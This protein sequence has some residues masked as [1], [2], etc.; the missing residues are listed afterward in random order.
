[1]HL[2][3]QTL[4]FGGGISS[5]VIDLLSL[6]PRMERLCFCVKFLTADRN[7]MERLPSF[8][9]HLKIL[10]LKFLDFSDMEQIFCSLCLIRSCPNLKELAISSDTLSSD[11]AVD[12][13]VKCMTVQY[14]ICCTL[15]NLSTV[16][17]K[18][19]TG[20]KGEL[21]LVKFLL[22]NSP[23]L[24]NLTF[25]VSGIRNDKDVL[26]SISQQ[27]LRFQRASPTAEIIFSCEG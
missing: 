8:F 14:S 15:R 2:S 3:P 24:V 16:K 5:N 17:I 20:F 11:S 23:S 22:A 18:A 4:N 21:E 25:K 7:Y 26:L 19:R 27:L 13:I 10:K 6:F 1:M 12:L 9:N